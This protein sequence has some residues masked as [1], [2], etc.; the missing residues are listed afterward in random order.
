MKTILSLVLTLL[1]AAAAVQASPLPAAPA[2]QLPAI[3]LAPPA[4]APAVAA[5]PAT[6][7]FLAGLDGTR[8]AAPLF[9]AKTGG[10]GTPATGP[11]CDVMDQNYCAQVLCAGCRGGYASCGYG[12][13]SDLCTTCNCFC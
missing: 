9:L 1:C 3:A 10:G 5:D 7:R 12:S 11:C 13:E 2:A 4:P 6:V 8:A